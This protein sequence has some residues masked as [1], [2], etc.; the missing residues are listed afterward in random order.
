MISADGLVLTASHVASQITDGKPVKITYENR[1]TAA[2][3]VLG[4]NVGPDIGLFK[5]ITPSHTPWPHVELAENAPLTGGFCFTYAHP[6]GKSKED[7]LS[8]ESGCSVA[9][10]S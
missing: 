6:A 9:G 8:Y 2:A 1:M 10:R 3:E 4:W 5:I 7:L